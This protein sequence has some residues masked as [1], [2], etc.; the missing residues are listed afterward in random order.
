MIVSQTWLN[1][2]VSLDMPLGE[3]TDKLTMSGLNLEGVEVVDG[4]SAIDLEVTSNRPDCLGHIGVAREVGVL[5]GQPLTIPE[6]D[7]S[8]GA[9]K[10]ADVTSVEIECPDLCPQ[11]VARVIKGV[12]VGPSPEWIASRLRTVGITPINNIVDITNY[13]LLECG[14][15]LHAFDF[16]KLKENRI[17]VRRAREGE[18]IE[19]IDHKT[20]PLTTDMC[21]IADAENPVAIGGVM[22]GASTEISD[23]TQ[24]VLIEVA[25]FAPLSIRGTARK[26]SLFSDSTYRF[27]RGV[28]EQQLLWASNRCSELILATSGGILL[29]EPVIAGEIPQ[30]E[31][32]AVILRFDQI[33]RLLGIN[34]LPKECVRILTDLGMTAV[35]EAS[36]EMAAFTAPSWRRDLTRECDLIEEIG[37]IHG[38]DRVPEDIDIPVVAIIDTP[39]DVVRDRISDVLTAAGYHEAVTMSF[40]SREAFDLF[41]P[42]GDAEPLSVEHSSRKHENILRQS[43]VPSLL[44]SRRD[45]ERQGT[46]NARLFEIANVYLAAKPEDPKTQPTVLSLVTGDSFATLRGLVDAIAHAV[47][48]SATVTAQSVDVAQFAAGRGA[49]LL[50]NGEH[51]G[52]LGEIDRSVTD[53][54]DLR[55]AVTVCEIELAP[56]I[57]LLERTPQY[58]S[59]PQ[60]PSMHRDLNFV[61]DDSVTWQELERIVQI[62]AGP[63]LDGVSFVDQ[64]RGK[65]IPTGKKSYVLT[66]AYRSPDRTLTS[67]EVDTAQKTVV[68]ACEQQLGAVQR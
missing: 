49:E 57:A 59:L 38:Y 29:D 62:S 6:A 20:Y 63:L 26:L 51:W 52:W 23:R 10:T 54:L 58:E 35:G 44:V 8:T 18:T 47:N 3:L 33:S 55:D 19:A 17:V 65:Q 24:N 34:I 46:F 68:A 13:V 67:E 27:E 7:V 2:Y 36:D 1:E 40:V 9:E 30:W 42:R 14:Q 50:L 43:L 31:P 15:P 53:Q 48:G 64:Y 21:V 25:N 56:L 60:Y 37:R 41:T 11:Y 22:G 32:D 5:F 39:R 61:L 4:D 12:T 45:N 66:V 16:D 28:D